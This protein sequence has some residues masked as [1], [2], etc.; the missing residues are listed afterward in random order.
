MSTTDNQQSCS[1]PD[2]STHEVTQQE[3][4]LV[5]GGFLGGLVK[6]AGRAVGGL[7]R[8]VPGTSSKQYVGDGVP[9]D[10]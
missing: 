5:C 4:A 6:R 8:V 1:L 7:P 9:E 3:L 2:P 10:L